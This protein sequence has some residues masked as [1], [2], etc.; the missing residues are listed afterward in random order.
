MKITI[1][2]KGFTVLTALTKKESEKLMLFYL[3]K[4]KPQKTV[5]RISGRATK[6]NPWV[7][8]QKKQCAE[9]G[10][11]FKGVNL[12]Q[13][14]RFNHP[15]I[16]PKNLKRAYTKRQKPS[17]GKEECPICHKMKKGLKMH[18]RLVHGQTGTN[19]G[20]GFAAE[21]GTSPVQ[22]HDLIDWPAGSG[23]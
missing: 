3:G 21:K 16:A 13:H 14:Y 9:E 11:T 7:G 19:T 12:V 17:K 8:K 6:E 23:R 2:T 22:R 5:E 18:L 10:C 20:T 4:D 1:S 15:G